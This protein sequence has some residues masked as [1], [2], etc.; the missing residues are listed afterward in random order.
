MEQSRIK[1]MKQQI[2][3]AIK[4]NDEW[5]KTPEGR[6]FDA[7]L[8]FANN[9]AI[10]MKHKKMT[11]ADLCAAIG[12]KQPQ[13]S[14]IMAGEEN[15]GLLVLDRIADGLGIDP[16]RLVRKPKETVSVE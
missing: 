1:A 8:R 9:L 11:Q 13:M 14:R 5:A 10:A 4:R 7:R 15:I 2:A 12:M 3:D 6:E 16:S